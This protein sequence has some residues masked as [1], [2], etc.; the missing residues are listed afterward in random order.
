[1]DIKTGTLMS[2]PFSA[3]IR[4]Q[5]IDDQAVMR[6]GLRMLL[7]SRQGW[8]V[9]GEASSHKEAVAVASR[10]QPDL[11]LLDFVLEGIVDLDLIPKLLAVAPQARIVVLTSILDPQL[12]QQAI[13]RGAMGLVL[14]KHAADVL[15]KAIEKVYAGEVWLDRSTI[16]TFIREMAHVDEGSH[17]PVSV[18]IIESLTSREREVIALLA[19]GLKN[20]QVAERLHISETTV[21]HYLTSIFNKLDVH[22]RV[23]LIMYAY[24]YGLA[25][26]PR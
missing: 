19:E 9:V 14:K 7:E 11:I 25:T 21:R 15:L 23:E 6:T 10:E 17:S 13:R 20:K 1:M 3:A 5:L 22:D 8:Q 12:H 26:P 4:L 24:R 2:V 18:S 16:T